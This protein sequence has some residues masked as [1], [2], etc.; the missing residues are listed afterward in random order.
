MTSAHL[1][2]ILLAVIAIEAFVLR[3]WIARAPGILYGL[4]SGAS[5]VL[6]LGAAI[7][8]Q[9]FPAIAGCLS[10]SLVFHILELR[11]WLTVIKRLPA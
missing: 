8:Q 4:L 9:G 1:P 11:Q 5:L 3:R 2:I 6:A 7:T 10:L